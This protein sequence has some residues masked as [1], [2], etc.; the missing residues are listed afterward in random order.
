LC[1]RTSAAIAISF[2]GPILHLHPELYFHVQSAIAP[3][4]AAISGSLLDLLASSLDKHADQTGRQIMKP[5]TSLREQSG[6]VAQPKVPGSIP[7][8]GPGKTI[9]PG[10]RY[11]QS[12]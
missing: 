12:Q 1:R 4:A 7:E 8:S 10:V 2:V 9:H 3:T 5:G 6:H 11:N